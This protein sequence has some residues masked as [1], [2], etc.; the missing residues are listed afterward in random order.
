MLLYKIWDELTNLLSEYLDDTIEFLLND[1]TVEEFEWISEVFDDIADITQSIEFIDCLYEVEKKFKGQY[2]CNILGSIDYA[3]LCLDYFPTDPEN[4]PIKLKSGGH[5]Q[6]NIELLKKYK[7]EYKIVQTYDNGVR[8]GFIPNHK[9]KT[10]PYGTNQAWFPEDW[11]DNDI[12]HAGE[13]V[14]NLRNNIKSQGNPKF[15]WY[16]GVKV[17][18]FTSQGRV[19]AIFPDINQRR[20]KK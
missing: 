17:G 1:C 8:V 18:I 7:I 6:K 15:A 5:G 3:K 14:A 19:T 10:K 2:K 16:K 4:E 20:D 9:I 13:H 11:T 12:K